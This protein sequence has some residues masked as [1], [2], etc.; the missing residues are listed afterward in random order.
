M[1]QWYE[2]LQIILLSLTAYFLLTYDRTTI[3]D[4]DENILCAVTDEYLSVH[5]T[6]Y[7]LKPPRR[8]IGRDRMYIDHN[9]YNA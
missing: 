8:I 3:D 2:T 6:K 5:S 7:R 9:T 1:D 4:A